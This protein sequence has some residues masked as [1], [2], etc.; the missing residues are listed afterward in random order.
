MTCG[1]YV[2]KFSGTDKVYIGMSDNIERRWSGHKH[3]LTKGTCS[4]KLQEAFNTYG[5][6]ILEVLCECNKEELDQLEREAIQIYDSI[7]NGFN[8]R[9]GGAI[10][11]GIGISGENNGRSKYSNEQIENAF[12][13]LITT[14]LTYKE[15]SSIT[16]VSLQAV[17]HIACGSGH[18]WLANKYPDEYN[19]LINTKKSGHKE[20]GLLYIIDTDTEEEY[21]VKSYK[22]IQ[23]LTGCAYTSAVSFVSGQAQHLFNK[24]KLKVPKPRSRLPKKKRYILKYTSTGEI[25]EVY[26]K[27]KFFTEYGLTN[28]KNL[29]DFL[30]GAKIGSNYQGWELVSVY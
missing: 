26:S 2:L 9:D 17:G 8:S 23:D 7:A 25:V 6:P 15:I 24:W 16:K 14:N 11:G 3:N 29:S 13:L 27:L 21:V 20:F 12:Q 18:K 5:L 19:K 4:P 30:D 22:E 1:I 10:G 28:R